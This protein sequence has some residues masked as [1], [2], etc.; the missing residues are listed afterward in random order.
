MATMP[1]LQDTDVDPNAEGAEAMAGAPPDD[2]GAPQPDGGDP[3]QMIGYIDPRLP[4]KIRVFLKAAKGVLISEQGA[5]LLKKVLA[6]SGDHVTALAQLVEKTIQNLETRLGPLTDVEHDKVAMFLTGWI[7]SSLQHMG[8]PG[9]DKPAGRQDLIGRILQALD[10]LTQDPQQ[11]G[12]PPGQPGQPG[13]PGAAPPPGGPPAPPQPG[14]GGTMPNLK[15][16]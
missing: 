8:M 1:Q 16:M 3:A 13:Q 6:S 11:Q 12:Q 4:P 9:L 2:Q 5:A 15:G 10:G 14:A 7:V